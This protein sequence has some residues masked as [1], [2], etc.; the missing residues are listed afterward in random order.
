MGDH[1]QHGELATTGD[2]RYRRILWVALIV[3][4][5]MFGVEVI[6][7]TLSASL[8][9]L[10]NSLDFLGDAAN[11]GISLW[12]LD[13]ALSIRAKAAMIKAITMAAFGFWVLVGFVLRAYNNV[14]PDAAAMGLVGL[15]AMF[16]N[17]GVAVLLYRYRTGDSNM[18]S[19]W[20]CSR[21]DA[22]GNVAV[23]IAGLV[24]LA[25]GSAWPD[26]LVAMIMAMLA[27][28]SAWQVMAQASKELK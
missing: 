7:G 21:N 28:G 26:M 8:S 17:I 25:T 22:I 19:V 18:R 12:V 27:I 13:M 20:I 9:L 14:I 3:N 10:A 4:A 11:Y 24:I 1:H 15:L 2:P 16:A 5:L 23:I 6:A